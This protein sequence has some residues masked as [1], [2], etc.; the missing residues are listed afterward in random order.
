MTIMDVICYMAVGF[1]FAVWAARGWARR[2]ET[3]GSSETPDFQM[4]L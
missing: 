3:Y 1:K 4:R 2:A